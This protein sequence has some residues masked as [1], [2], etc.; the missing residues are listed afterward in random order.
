MCYNFFVCIFKEVCSI[1]FQTAAKG[2][3]AFIQKNPTAFHT[4]ASIQAALS[5]AGYTELE[6]SS[7]WKL[8]TG[9]G[10]FVNRNG[11]SVIAI[12][13][14]TDLEAYSFN[15]TACH[16]D[17]PVFKVKEKAEIR[18]NNKYTK[19][20]VEG[21]GG[22]LCG[23]WFDRPLSVAGRVIV[24]Q[25]D[26]SIASKLVDLNR[27]LA[28]IPSVAIHMN[29][30]ANE[31][32]AF[33]KQVDMLPLFA[34]QEDGSLARLVAEEVGVEEKQILGSDL[35][36]YCRDR[37]SL[38][39]C[40][41]EFVSSSR[42]DDQQ[43]VYAALEGFLGAENA[44]SI[45]VL[46]CFDN[47]EVG[48]GTKQ[49]AASTFLYDVLKRVH[50]ALGMGE[51]EFMRAL[52]SSFLFSADN[53][54]AVHPNHPEY[55]DVDNCAYLNEGVVVKFHAGQKYT[56][57]GV[58]SAVARELASRAKIPLQF[59]ANRSDQTGGSTLGNIAMTHVSVRAVDIGLPQLAMHSCYETAGVKDT[60]YMIELLKKFYGSHIE[61]AA[62]GTLRIV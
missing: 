24:R 28:L 62:P 60:W 58:S 31:G 36:L 18:V 30:K 12:R 32:Y 37:P 25:D 49:G 35:Y 1:V 17:S 54:Q 59:Y 38:W 13:I 34:G 23:P 43:C 33:N 27:D 45:N 55:A 48:S 56:S 15:I 5:Q 51:E 22:M 16:T 47:E 53:A 21:Y 2:M 14:G 26:G 40:H 4:A 29:R 39:G 19:F 42:L 6:E 11:S 10:Y 52:A 7:P 61:T 8:Q 50:L 44:R 57:D 20:N 46:A 3:I 9:A 41:E